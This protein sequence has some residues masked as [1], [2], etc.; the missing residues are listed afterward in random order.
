MSGGPK[1][2]PSGGIPQRHPRDTR[3]GCGL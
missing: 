1:G 3:C 2:F